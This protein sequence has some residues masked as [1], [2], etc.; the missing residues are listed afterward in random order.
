[1]K[2]ITILFIL[3]M[4]LLVG[5]DKQIANI[6]EIKVWDKDFNVIQIINQAEMI[7][8]VETIWMAKEKVKLKKKPN[9]IYKIDIVSDGKFTRW[10][11]DLSG[12]A[13]ILSKAKMPIYQIEETDKFNK[14][15][16]P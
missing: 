11:Y 15:I 10:L 7:D 13:T 12:Y 4:T 2:T 14:I 6:S 1:M 16:I 3:G 9:F 5:C 8:E